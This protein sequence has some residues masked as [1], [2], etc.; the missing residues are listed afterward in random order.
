MKKKKR[1]KNPFRIK[2][3]HLRPSQI[4]PLGF[5]ALI[6]GGALL[7]MLP[8][9]TASGQGTDFS[10]ALFTSTTSVCVTGNVVVDTYSYWSLFGQIVI[11][12]LIQ[13]GGLGIVAVVSLVVVTASRRKSLLNMMLLKDSFNLESMRGV[14]PFIYRVF[15]GTLV[16]EGLGA[17]GYAFAFLPQ[18]GALKGIWYSIFTSVSAFCNAGMDVMG[19]N[20]LANYYNKP[21]VLIVTMF[22]IVAGGIGYVVWFDI[23][24]THRNYHKKA[25]KK[26]LGLNEHTKLVLSLTGALILGGAVF[27]YF[28]ERNN[29]ATIGN[30]N[31]WEKILNSTFQSVTYRTAGFTT[32]PQ[33]A[34]REP[35]TL[36]GD[37]LMFIG[38]SPVGTAGGVKTVT[39]YV[40][41]V[42]V[43]SCM[44]GNYEPTA[45]N[46]RITDE[47]IRKAT[48]IVVFHFLLALI[49]ST[50]L[51]IYEGI[52]FIDSIYEIMS[53]LNT[54]GVTRGVTP[55]LNLEGR[56]I[57]I[58]AMY[59]GRIGPVSMALF[60]P[61]GPD[62]RVKKS[63]GR[64]IVG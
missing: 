2:K 43:D 46:R 34:L 17:I 52:P 12:F 35:T 28:L 30:M 31:V 44:R 21:L 42:N 16:V 33:E 18:F 1:K 63:K 48:A 49:F 11:L 29:E 58:A 55:N 6:L 41:M 50:A 7:L 9:S 40:L 64:F 25:R 59:L 3:P 14:A 45:F 56:M 53:G 22:L 10:T 32:I 26:G 4:I 60:F 13:M 39:L 62:G 37:I 8:I 27:I 54:V 24:T 20:S 5:L 61:S 36:V 38:G 57:M 51:M 23:W 15:K 47:M 19:P